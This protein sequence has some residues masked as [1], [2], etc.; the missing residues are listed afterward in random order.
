MR[1][2]YFCLHIMYHHENS[3]RLLPSPLN[4]PPTLN[5]KMPPQCQWMTA[6][7]PTIRPTVC[8]KNY[9]GCRLFKETCKHTVHIVNLF[10]LLQAFT[11]PDC[12]VV[13]D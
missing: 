9:Q 11:R 8:N 13:F 10:S 5:T 4:A 2:H 12:V 3:C 7:F 6:P 1:S